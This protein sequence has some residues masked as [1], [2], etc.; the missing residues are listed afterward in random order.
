M[1]GASTNPGGPVFAQI[2][3]L[4]ELQIRYHLSPNGHAF[5]FHTGAADFSG[6]D[7]NKN[8]FI[9]QVIHQAYIDVTESGTTAAA[10]TA[11]VIGINADF[12]SYSP[13]PIPFTVDHPFIFMIVENATNTVLFMGRVDDPLSTS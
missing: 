6:I 12:I 5:G 7:G 8:L 3:F 11:V 10:A 4:D 9:S 2:H 1:T 13:P